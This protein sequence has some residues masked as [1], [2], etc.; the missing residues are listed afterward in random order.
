[1]NNYSPLIWHCD[2][3]SSPFHAWE[4]HF[5]D[6]IT[7]VTNLFVKSN[8]FL[9]ELRQSFYLYEKGNHSFPIDGCFALLCTYC[10]SLA[11]H[12]QGCSNSCTNPDKWLL[13]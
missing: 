9:P 5:L 10:M 2:Y 12:W 3:K 7:D 4:S 13:R 8:F 11:N 6:Y 1:M